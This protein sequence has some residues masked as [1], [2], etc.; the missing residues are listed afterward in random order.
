MPLL[1]LYPKEM[2]R[3]WRSHLHRVHYNTVHSSQEISLSVQQ[4]TN[5]HNALHIHDGMLFCLIKEG[6]P[7]IRD[8]VKGTV[9][10]ERSQ[11]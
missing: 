1:D 2:D 7:S 9:F 5:G 10:S 3:A 8:N 4:L 11:A 6:N